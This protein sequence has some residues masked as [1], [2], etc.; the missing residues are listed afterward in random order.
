MTLQEAAL[1]M[2]T[3]RRW[4]CH[5][6]RNDANGFPKVPITRDWSNL[7]PTSEVIASL[8]WDQAIGLGIVLGEKS[9]NLAALDID[10]ADLAKV[11]MDVCWDNLGTSPR[12]VSTARNRLHVYVSEI[13]GASNST[14]QTVQWDGRDVT[15]ELKANGT[16]IAAPP[17][18]GYSLLNPGQ[19]PWPIW[20]VAQAW[21]HIVDC[22]NDAHPGRLSVSQD[23]FTGRHYP[24]PWQEEV[25]SG[26]RNEASYIEA[27]KLRE[28]GMSEEQATEVMR[29]RFDKAYEKQ[30]IT[31]EEIERTVQS[32]FRKGEVSHY[33]D[34]PGSELSAFGL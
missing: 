19:D 9:D 33:H 26:E 20:S 32:A 25:S 8:A 3:E 13:D 34:Q 28:S 12:L 5:P 2:F 30:G 17:S 1:Q 27:H 10:D 31:W 11:I 29:V 4:L 16:Q 6:L 7:D 23:P 14:K 18:P 15:I 24:Q 21:E 22:L